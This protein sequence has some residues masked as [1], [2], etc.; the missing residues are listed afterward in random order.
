[1][2]VLDEILAPLA[3]RLA[4]FAF[5]VNPVDVL[6]EFPGSSRD[7]VPRPLQSLAGAC[8]VLRFG[9]VDQV[10]H[11]VETVSFETH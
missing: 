11:V 4:R 2:R 9:L 8:D 1:M 3:E 6:S 7:R 5:P 10:D